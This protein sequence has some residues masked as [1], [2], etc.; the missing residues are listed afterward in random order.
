MADEN[1][2]LF[3]NPT[4]DPEIL[5]ESLFQARACLED[6]LDLIAEAA[7]TV[8]AVRGLLPR[9]AEGNV[10][11]DEDDLRKIDN[12]TLQGIA[13][14][15]DAIYAVLETLPEPPEG[16]DDGSAAGDDEGI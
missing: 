11:F 1:D 12:A 13:K 2:D 16:E 14:I 3:H 4:D 5:E 9:D 15:A 6:A 8:G 7:Y 10:E